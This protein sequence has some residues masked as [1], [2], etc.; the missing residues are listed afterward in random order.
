MSRGSGRR[1][2]G[3]WA[4]VLVV[5][6]V[7]LTNQVRCAAVGS[8]LRSPALRSRALAL[9]LIAAKLLYH[10]WFPRANAKKPN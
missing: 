4:V 8:G 3:G 9:T 10:A 5:G 6:V 2:A 1:A 7:A